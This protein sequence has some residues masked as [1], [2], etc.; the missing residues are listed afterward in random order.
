MFFTWN[1]IIRR[2]SLILVLAL[3]AV[4]YVASGA[5]HRDKIEGILSSDN[6]TANN[7]TKANEVFYECGACDSTCNSPARTCSLL[8]RKPECGCASGY[9]RNK[10]GKCVLPEECGGK[11]DNGCA[12]VDCE[13]GYVC[14]KGKCIPESAD[15][16]CAA[17]SCVANTTCIKGVC[18]MTG[19]SGCEYEYE[20]D[21]RGCDVPH[22]VCED[23]NCSE[24]EEAKICGACDI[25][26]GES[27]CVQTETCTEPECGCK[28]GFCRDENS[29]CVNSPSG[30]NGTVS[31][32]ASNSRKKKPKS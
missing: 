11:K 9:A 12:S 13:S 7:C 6:S 30:G 27:D 4:Y 8:C 19:N 28:A 29:T 2:C 32:D 5:K 17:V 1:L 23:L 25:K 3:P 26:C 24:N 10:R 22:L 21:E 15:G 31:D 18:V 20:T 16:S 14:N